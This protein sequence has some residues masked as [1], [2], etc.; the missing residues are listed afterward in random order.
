MEQKSNKN[1]INIPKKALIGIA[2]AIGILAVLL[3]RHKAPEALLFVIGIFCGILIGVNWIN[4][5]NK[6]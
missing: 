5:Q 3:S 1:F 2:P 4:G 6:N